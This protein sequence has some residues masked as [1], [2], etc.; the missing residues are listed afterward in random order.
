M[1]SSNNMRDG[2]RSGCEVGGEGRREGEGEEG[3]VSEGERITGER[4]SE[5]V[6][7]KRGRESKGE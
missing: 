1:K 3:R 6:E 4:E 5:G 7:T 2:G